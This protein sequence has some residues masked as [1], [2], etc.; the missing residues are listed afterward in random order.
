MLQEL[1]YS[2]DQLGQDFSNQGLVQ[3]ELHRLKFQSNHFN[4]V[5]VIDQTAHIRHIEPQILKFDA[6]AS[7]S[8]LGIV[9]SLK[10][11]QTYIS[12]PYSS[13]T[14]N[15]IVL[16]S[17]PIFSPE[18]QYLG[19]VTGTLYLQKKNLVSQILSTSYSYKNSYMFVVDS[20]RRIIF[21]PD[22]SR[23]G[24]T[25]KDNSGMD[26]M[27]QHKTGHI[28]LVN[29]QGINNL[30]G[31]A[32]IPSVNWLVVSQQPT[33]ALFQ[34]ANSIIIKVA[35]SFFIFY[36]VLF[37]IIW[38]IAKYISSPLNGLAQMAGMLNK[39]ET[40]HEIQN[41]DPWYFEVMRFRTALLFSSKKFK[42]KISE[43]N[44]HVNTDPLTGLHNR[45][46]MQLFLEE[47]QHMG[48]EFAVLLIDIDFFKL[49]ND[50]FGHDQ[51]DH[52]LRFLADQMKKNF[53]DNDV[54]CR[55]GGE[56]FAVL[57][58][59]TDREAVFKAAE[60][61][62][63]SVQEMTASLSTPITISIGVAFWPSDAQEVTEVFK[64]A[65][66]RLYQAKNQGRNQV[67]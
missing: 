35:F 22:A 21:H 15:L 2:A 55:L 8:T 6:K 62:R 7:Y 36:I 3:Q 14:N 65:D 51:G 16:M 58:A 5:S 50:R 28:Q 49:V 32:H 54:C 43:L 25:V 38:K 41:I 46:G 11:K 67:C 23:I 24:E 26:Y 64:Q 34:E 39:P 20:N 33:K 63:K 40:E 4:S 12:A 48:T 37:F 47:L 19:A 53:R 1:Q 27:Y 60:R 18:H 10:S 57:M 31:F 66:N 61:L 44:L 52:M 13:I 9:E 45:R 42:D 56:E 59:T 29:S 30:A 17:Q